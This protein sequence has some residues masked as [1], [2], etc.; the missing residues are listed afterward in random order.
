MGDILTRR[1]SVERVDSH[2]DPQLL[3]GRGEIGVSR[4]VSEGDVPC[5]DVLLGIEASG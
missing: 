4:A 3:G 1:N 2:R 5:D